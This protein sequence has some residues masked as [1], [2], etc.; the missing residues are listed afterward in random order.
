MELI[1]IFAEKLELLLNTAR[2]AM[3]VLTP[4]RQ[5][6]SP[7]GMLQMTR[8]FLGLLNMVGGLDSWGA[9]LI[10]LTI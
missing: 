4:P 3:T 2:A 10:Q 1:E 7:K 6:I 8:R 5:F 9:N